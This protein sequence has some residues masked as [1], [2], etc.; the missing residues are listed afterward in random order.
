MV[1]M[2]PN[3]ELT[4]K[5]GT[6]PDS[7]KLAANANLITKTMDFSL[8]QIIVP[9]T[10]GLMNEELDDGSLLVTTSPIGELP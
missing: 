8:H 2:R 3:L 10:M 9:I 6:Q 4:R 5:C 7:K 1:S